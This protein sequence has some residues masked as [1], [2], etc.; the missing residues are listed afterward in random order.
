MHISSLE[1]KNFKRFTDLTVDLSKLAQPPKL[2]LLIGANGSGKSSVFDGFETLLT[3]KRSG[4]TTA[5]SS[6]HAKSPGTQYSVKVI[7]VGKRT[8]EFTIHASD[9]ITHS[10]DIDP[11]SFYGRTSLRQV[12]RLT[13]TTLGQTREADFQKDT[14]HPYVY[15][16]RDER[17]ENDIEE[18]VQRMLAKVFDNDDFNAQRFKEKYLQ[19]INK[20]LYRIF[21]SLEAPVLELVSLKPPMRGSV[22]N[23]QFRKGTAQFHYDLLS[24][25]EKEVINILFDLFM[26]SATFKDTIYFIDELDLHLNANRQL[27]SIE[28]RQKA[29]IF[30]M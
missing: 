23:I 1:L 11:R 21:G 16:D 15:I 2:V 14:D 20:S 30:D 18:L 25:G 6:Y 4:N 9:D 7:P 19:R 17:F 3:L 5:P 26:R 12:P 28:K 8:L 29:S 10:E 24:S 27:G 22:A 13:R